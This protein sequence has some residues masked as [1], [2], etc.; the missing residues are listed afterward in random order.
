MKNKKLKDLSTKITINKLKKIQRDN[1]CA[2]TGGL[3][4]YHCSQCTC[5]SCRPD[6]H[7]NPDCWNFS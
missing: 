2:I 7:Q 1:L 3:A 5:S 6:L 4:H